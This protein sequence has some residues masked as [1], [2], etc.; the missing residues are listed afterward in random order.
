MKELESYMRA[1]RRVTLHG[2]DPAAVVEEWRDV[3]KQYKTV[4][5]QN[6]SCVYCHRK[7]LQGFIDQLTSGIDNPPLTAPF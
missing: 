4:L 6:K 7:L 1:G 5:E 3:A 2:S